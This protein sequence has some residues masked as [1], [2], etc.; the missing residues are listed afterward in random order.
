VVAAIVATIA[1]LT[2]G[3]YKA[4]GASPLPRIDRG[5]PSPSSPIPTFTISGRVTESGTGLPIPM[6]AVSGDGEDTVTALDGSYTIAR[7]GYGRWAVSYKHEGFEDR[8]L[9][10]VIQ[11]DEKIDVHLQRSSTIAAGGRLQATLYPDDP[12]YLINSEQ[13]CEP[14]KLVR[15]QVDRAG[16]LAFRVVFVAQL[17]DFDV[18]IVSRNPRMEVHLCCGTE[19]ARKMAVE[20]GEV[21]LYISPHD[22]SATQAQPFE[23]ITQ[24]S[25]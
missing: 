24:L 10:R 15:I 19:L 21:I 9:V 17:Q 14:C 12:G 6:V 4:T 16:T 11:G 5:V 18:A 3:C 2:G 23:V 20:P 25:P 13:G 8:R 22:S 1:T 7:V